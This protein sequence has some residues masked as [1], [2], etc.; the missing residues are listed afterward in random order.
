M[1]S[2]TLWTPQT[3][4]TADVF[5]IALYVYLC[6]NIFNIYLCIPDVYVLIVP[7]AKLG[8][9]FCRR[10]LYFDKYSVRAYASFCFDLCQELVLKYH[11]WGFDDFS[12]TKG[13]LLHFVFHC[14]HWKDRLTPL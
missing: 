11:E 10:V 14:T 7:C 13:P 1:P 9:S 6:T 2:L 8:P 3:D 4:A 5:I 12:R